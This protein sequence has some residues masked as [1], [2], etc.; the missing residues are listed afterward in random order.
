M[1][2][3][4]IFLIVVVVVLL[5]WWM[6]A[7]DE[8]EVELN[9]QDGNITRPLNSI[10]DGSIKFEYPSDFGLAVS[11]E[12]ILTQSYIPPC[13][14][15]FDYCFYYYGDDFNGTNFE[16]AGIRVYRR[17]D[18][19]STSTCLTTPKTGYPNLA[20][21]STSTPRYAASVFSPIGDAGAG[22][23]A[24]GEEYRLYIDKACYEI[25]TQIGETQY[26]NYEPGSI[27]EFGESD[28]NLV[29]QYFNSIL[30]SLTGTT[31]VGRIVLPDSEN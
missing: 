5:I 7:G 23:F 6:M 17:N 12:Q 25:E 22:H 30:G 8:N 2:K 19:T 21:S 28:R 24:S 4:I 3:F 14:E 18:L 27:R 15:N 13:G 26:S 31:T 16:S 29:Y 11:P 10:S 1:K 9:A 20:P